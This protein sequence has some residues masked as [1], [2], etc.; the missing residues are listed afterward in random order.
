MIAERAAMPCRA[1]APRQAADLGEED[2]DEA[3]ADE[4]E[5]SRHGQ[6]GKELE[7]KAGGPAV[8][9]GVAKGAAGGE[10]GGDEGQRDRGPQQVP[11]HAGRRARAREE[12]GLDGEEA[13]LLLHG[14]E[15]QR[16]LCGGVRGRGGV[17]EREPPRHTRG[18]G[19]AVH[20]MP[21]SWK[22]TL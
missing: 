21:P 1:H 18:G 10:V 20:T 11:G 16:A 9:R 5:K 14:G 6:H 12:A 22:S 4:P 15:L 19:A 13:V 17:C 8:H 2:G 3:L 7:G